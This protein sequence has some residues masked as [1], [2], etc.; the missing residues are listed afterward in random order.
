MDKIWSEN[1]SFDLFS[2][3][4]KK[5]HKMKNYAPQNKIISV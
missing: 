4:N 5:N 3:Q 1:E 2:G